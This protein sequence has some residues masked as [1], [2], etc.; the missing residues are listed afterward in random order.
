M[1]LSDLCLAGSRDPAPRP[2]SPR[3]TQHHRGSHSFSRRPQAG[4][5]RERAP[6]RS[7]LRYRVGVCPELA[8]LGFGEAGL[9]LALP[10]TQPRPGQTRLASQRPFAGVPPPVDAAVP[11]C[12]P[13]PSAGVAA[14]CSAWPI[15]VY[16]YAN[17]PLLLINAPVWPPVLHQASSFM[18]AIEPRAAVVCR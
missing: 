10:P 18:H 8:G 5:F 15:C 13:C 14:L 16:I 4:S 12:S 1:G 11:S 17:A 9:Q 2:Q 6:G 7:D 3:R